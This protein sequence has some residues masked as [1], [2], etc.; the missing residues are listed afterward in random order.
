VGVKTRGL[1]SGDGTANERIGTAA[2][3]MIAVDMDGTLLGLNGR[4]SADNLAA[5]RAAE[6]AG[7]EVVVATGRR[8]CYAMRILREL[9]LGA[10]RVL[11]SSNGAVT[12]TIGTCAAG[13][14]TADGT[15]LLERTLLAR[16][17][18]LWLCAH[19]AE[20]RNA[21]VITFDKVQPDG[22]DARG[23]LV[24]EEL[25]ELHGSIGRWME[26]N[27]AYIEH[28]R[29]IERALAGVDG[30]AP[31]QMML[32]GTIE[33]MRRAEARL[34]EDPRVYA[35]GVSAAERLATAEITLS[36]TEYPD[37]D[38]SLVDIL[39]AG[40]SKG[41]ALLR[42]AAGRGIAPAEMMAI[43]DNWNDLSMLEIAGRPVLM[44]NA[45]EEL[46][47]MAQERGWRIGGHHDRHGVAR[48]IEEVLLRAG[49]GAS[50]AM[51]G[52]GG[53]VDGASAVV[54]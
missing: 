3:R 35:A 42:L 15:R 31:I 46:K 4:V 18:A 11:V 16:E 13:M 20:F 24:V 22:E 51:D 6:L 49:N 28:V 37:R 9:G 10:E 50:G 45:P 25:E 5:L 33:R 54:A 26:A 48:A 52:T 7:V 2:I 1:A 36:R 17:T 23:A 19:L 21:L 12:R 34:L 53:A 43:G 14:A 30:A 29:P 41:M 27:A 38:L 44:E 8:H 32:C 39:P 40:C 47:A